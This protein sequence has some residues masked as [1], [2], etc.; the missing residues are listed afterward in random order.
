MILYFRGANVTF[1][2]RGSVSVR[3][4]ASRRKIE[5]MILD[6]RPAHERSIFSETLKKYF[7][8]F[9]SFSSIFL[10]EKFLLKL[11]LTEG[12]SHSTLTSIRVKQDEE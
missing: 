3:E 1:K 5:Y 6:L 10:L 11:R 4:G 7:C 12:P 8:N 9:F 2:L